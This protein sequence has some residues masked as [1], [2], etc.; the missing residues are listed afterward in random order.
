MK[1]ILISIL[2]IASTMLAAFSPLHGYIP[3][4]GTSDPT[5]PSIDQFASYVLTGAHEITGIYLSDVAALPVVQQPAGQP[6]FVS[7]QDEQVT[8]FGMASQYGSIGIL[9]HNT[10]AGRYFFQLQPNQ[11]VTL[12][13]GDGELQTY[14]IQQVLQYQALRPLDPYTNF[15]DLQTQA[16]VD[17]VSVFNNVYAAEGRL[18]LQTCIEANGDESWG[19]L[20][21]IA[22]P[23]EMDFSSPY[24]TLLQGS[25]S[26][27]SSGLQVANN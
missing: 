23:F 4:T 26:L 1:R 2:V 14:R 12:T 19:R 18:V 3:V 24:K 7:E 25:M 22:E 17:V 9:A 15:V 10:L 11:I 21:I 5:L 6:G 16:V 13:Y 8:Q 27:F 20:F